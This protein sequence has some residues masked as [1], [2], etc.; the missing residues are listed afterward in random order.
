MCVKTTTYACANSKYSDFIPLFAHST[1]YHNNDI[2]VEIGVDNEEIINSEPIKYIQNV[3]K[4][5]FCIH[6]VNWDKLHNVKLCPGI[7]RFV[8]EPQ[9]K[10]KYIYF[11]DIDMLNLESNITDIN[12][13]QMLNNG[14]QYNNI[15]RPYSAR[16]TG[17]HFTHWDTYYPLNNLQKYA[18]LFSHDENFL[19]EWASRKCCLSYDRG[20]IP[21][22]GIHCCPNHEIQVSRRWTNEWHKYRNSEEFIYLEKFFSKRIKDFI[23]TIDGALA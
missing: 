7:I 10:N 3:Y 1:L 16:M 9:I 5:R 23:L 20:F 22:H 17:L 18:H 12:I 19:F 8:T 14:L 2:A 13:K 15:I 6:I 21:Q 11:C 4:D